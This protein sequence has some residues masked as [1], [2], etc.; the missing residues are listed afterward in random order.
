MSYYIGGVPF[1]DDHLA[2][3]G[4]LGMKWGVRRYENPDG[5]LTAKGRARYG[6]QGKYTYTSASTRR[7]Q[8]RADRLSGKADRAAAKG[9][10]EKAVR[11]HADAEA[12]REKVERSKEMDSRM[13]QYARSVTT[14][15]NILS[16]MLTNVG[17]RPY[18]ELLSSM[19][20]HDRSSF[21][22]K[23]VSHLLA[24]V[25]GVI[26][27]RALTNV[28]TVAGTLL[29]G[30]AGGVIGGY[31]G[32]IGGALGGRKLAGKIGRDI[33]VNSNSKKRS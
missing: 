1:G 24:S 23:L 16:R 25:G 9:K 18:T 10:F 29:A 20:G 3:Y 5:T 21:G 28:G 13:E 15:G 6:E 7:L 8:K 32:M 14:G 26:G 11:L 19:G 27:M 17:T 12:K 30:P 33:Y 31:A 4:V 2:H 22:K